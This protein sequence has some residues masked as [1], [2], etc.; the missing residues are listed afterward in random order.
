MLTHAS[1]QAYIPKSDL[2]LQLILIYT[3]LAWF[4]FILLYYQISFKNI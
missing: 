2:L 4:V 1:N 3:G